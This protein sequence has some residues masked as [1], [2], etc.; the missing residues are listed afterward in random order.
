MG[1]IKFS[2]KTQIT[3]FIAFIIVFVIG[4]TIVY[5]FKEHYGE[6]QKFEKAFLQEALEHIKDLAHDIQPNI[7]ENDY[8]GME[9]E[10]SGVKHLPYL[11]YVLITDTE[12][13]IIMHS[14]R[15]QMGG[16]FKA[17]EF[18]K[19]TEM[20]GGLIQ[21]YHGRGGKEFIEVAYPIKA[22]DLILGTAR[23]GL[24]R[25][26]FEEALARTKQTLFVSFLVAL[27]AILVGVLF[28]LIIASRI[29]RPILYLSQEAKEVGKGD[30]NRKV[31]IKRS[32]EI[33]ELAISFN[34]MVEDLRSSTDKLVLAKDYTDNILKSMI[35]TLI[36]V[37][38]QAKI[39]SVNQATC[40]LL[41]YKEEEII[42]KDV[43]LIFT[44]EEEEEEEEEE[45]IFRGTRFQRLLKEGSIMNYALTYRTKAG[46]AI[47]VSLSGRAMR[48]K[49]D[50]LVGIVGVARDMREINKLIKELEDS[51]AK[52]QER[53]DDLERFRKATVDREFRMEELRK[54]IEELKA[55]LGEKA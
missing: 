48:D 6:M 46:E 14:Q 12:N 13:K 23:I 32:D 5:Q 19:T 47:P 11:D 30:Y 38:P 26:W 22:E 51:K 7:L 35:D 29:A 37:D 53:L 3:V 10:L 44:E 42:G 2:L 52:L 17:P 28:S 24:T 40:D 31:S 8:A 15:E 50:K 55:R 41:G 34:Q 18:F 49:E 21:R 16:L 27:G 33:G 25:G 54:T 45:R 4:V 36:V 20:G 39:K 1:R 9:Y 43:S